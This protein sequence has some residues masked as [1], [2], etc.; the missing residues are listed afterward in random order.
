[1][2]R[3][4]VSGKELERQLGVCRTA[5]RIGYQLRLLIIEGKFSGPAVPA[6]P[7]APAAPTPN[8]KDMIPET[9]RLPG[10]CFS[11]R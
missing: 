8:D 11:D 6:A 9:D 3:G 5:W 4:G 2:K 1:M 7:A 10:S